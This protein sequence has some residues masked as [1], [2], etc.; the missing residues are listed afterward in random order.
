MQLEDVR[1]W[2]R[3]TCGRSYLQTYLRTYAH[4]NN[5]IDRFADVHDTIN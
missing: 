5:A 3:H 4:A 2:M 1:A